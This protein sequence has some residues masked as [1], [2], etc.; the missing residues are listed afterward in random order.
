MRYRA[1]ARYRIF[2]ATPDESDGRPGPE[3]FIFDDA[4]SKNADLILVLK[5]SDVIENGTHEQLLR[6]VGFCTELYNSQ[7]EDVS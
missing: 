6:Q 3:I 5:D 2:T 1:G 7:F 4:L